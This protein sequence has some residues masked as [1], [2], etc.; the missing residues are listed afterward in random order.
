MR[1]PRTG[2]PVRQSL[3]NS[4]I[5]CAM[6]RLKLS[7]PIVPICRRI[8]PP[9]PMCMKDDHEEKGRLGREIAC[10]QDFE[11]AFAQC[12]TTTF[13]LAKQIF[14][15]RSPHFPPACTSCSRHRGFCSRHWAPLPLLDLFFFRGPLPT[16]KISCSE[17]HSRPSQI[18]PDT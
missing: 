9:P 11:C 13:S 15:L 2:H 14:S 18:L 1:V 12:N 10:A 5:P 7:S 6:F 4:Q 17:T 8:P 16:A 3:G